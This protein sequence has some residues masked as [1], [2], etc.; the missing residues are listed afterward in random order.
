MRYVIGRF[1]V[2][3]GKRPE[4]LDH[5]KAYVAA[6]RADKGCVYFDIAPAPDDPDG[7]VMVECWDTE[8]NHKAHQSSAYAAAFNPTF[9]ALALRGE[10][11]EMN[12]DK[13]DNV[14][15]DFSK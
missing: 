10:F 1:T 12:V 15:F 4:F 8:D 7:C 9:G 14:A 2:R 3:S 11:Q 5:A 13:P 6:S